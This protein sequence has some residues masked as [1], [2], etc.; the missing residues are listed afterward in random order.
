MKLTIACKS[1]GGT[2]DSQEILM[3]CAMFAPITGLIIAV[4]TAIKLWGW[5]DDPVRVFIVILYLIPIASI[6][7]ILA[8]TGI[9]TVV[10]KQQKHAK[11]K[12]LLK[13]ITEKFGPLS[14]ELSD[15]IFYQIC[16]I[17]SKKLEGLTKSPINAPNLQEFLKTL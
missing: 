8:I 11:R 1:K 4:I 16:R 10:P 15:D 17:N 5:P 3:L 13:K 14:D 12:L 2:M 7:I 9:I 6:T